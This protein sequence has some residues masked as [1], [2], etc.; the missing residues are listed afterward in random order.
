MALLPPSTN[1]AYRGSI[2]AAWFLALSSVTTIVPGLIHYFL[3]DG[4]AGVIGGVDLSTRAD[5][6]IAIF[7]WYGAMQ[8]PFGF[9]ILI[10][11]LRYRTLV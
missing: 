9:L 8:I 2:L 3:P 6:I 1:A 11:A 10:I 4:G 5:T 7:A